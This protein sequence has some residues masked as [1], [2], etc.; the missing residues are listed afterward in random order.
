MQNLLHGPNVLFYL[1]LYHQPAK[2]AP[3][4]KLI[5]VLSYIKRYGGKIQSAGVVGF[6]GAIRFSSPVAYDALGLCLLK[7]LGVYPTPWRAEGTSR[8]TEAFLAWTG[9]WQRR[10]LRLSIGSEVIFAWEEGSQ[11]YYPPSWSSAS[12]FNQLTAK[13]EANKYTAQEATNAAEELVE[14]AMEVDEDEI[15]NGQI[16]DEDNNN[17]TPSD[18]PGLQKIFQ[19]KTGKNKGGCDA[20]QGDLRAWFSEAK[21]IAKAGLQAFSDASNGNKIAQETLKQFLGIDSSTPASDLEDTKSKSPLWLE[22]IVWWLMTLIVRLL[23]VYDFLTGELNLDIGRPWLFCGSTWLEQKKRDDPSLTSS[24]DVKHTSQGNP[25]QIQNDP[26]Y[27]DELWIKMEGKDVPSSWVP[28]W[29][30]DLGTYI[31]DLDYAGKGYCTFTGNL[32]TTPVSPP[33]VNL[34][35]K[36]F[37]STQMAQKL[38]G[39]RGNSAR[40]QDLIPRSGTLFHELFHLVYGLYETPDASCMLIID[41]PCSYDTNDSL[42]SL[43]TLLNALKSPNGVPKSLSLDEPDNTDQHYENVSK[44]TNLELVRENPETWVYFCVSYWYT[45]NQNVYF[46]NG[47]TGVSSG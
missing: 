16:V 37:T 25:L 7:E 46:P 20:H 45:L 2:A 28:Y 36:S 26:L 41:I 24:G 17:N 47:K 15:E 4:K 3:A 10:V 6:Q 8:M 13:E 19:I 32:A 39:R 18:P 9:H 42:D 31:F 11:P 23:D 44:L 27:R 12:R 43:H 29:S 22:L 30:S 40:L 35:P 1:R 21:E 5:E 14:C 33:I 34:C 38:G